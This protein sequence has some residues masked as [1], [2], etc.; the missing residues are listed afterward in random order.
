MARISSEQAGGANV[1]AFL[2]MIA[3]SEL[4]AEILANPLADDGYRVIVG[5]LPQNVIVFSNYAHHPRL[6]VELHPG[7]KSTAAGRYMFI[8]PTWVNLVQKLGLPDISPESQDLAGIELVRECGALDD[9]IAG[10][11]EAAVAA[12]SPTWASLPGAGYGQHENK[13]QDL[14]AAYVAA[15][16]TV[17]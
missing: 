7:L 8:V 2:D 15:G 10:N 16:G 11:F 9:V 12:C 4:G 14:I 3:T 17:A 5:S 1:L 6:L 13:M